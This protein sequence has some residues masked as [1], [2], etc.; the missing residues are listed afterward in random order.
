MFHRNHILVLLLVIPSISLAQVAFFEDFEEGFLD[1]L[2]WR[3][4]GTP[5]PVV[6]ASEGR[7]GS[8]ALDCN[9]DNQYC[10]AVC[11]QWDY[12]LSYLP[13]YSFYARGYQS[14]Y[15]WQ[16][17]E[18]GFSRMAHESFSGGSWNQ[19]DYLLGIALEPKISAS[20]IFYFL[21][22]DTLFHDWVPEVHNDVWLSFAVRIN[23]DGTASF[24]M[25]D[26]LVF[27]TTQQLDL[28][29]WGEQ[30]FALKGQSFGHI[31]VLDDV[32][33][34]PASLREHWESGLNPTFWKLWGSPQP[35]IVPGGGCYG[36]AALNVNGEGTWYSGASSYQVFDI[37][38][39]PCLDF[40][41]RTDGSTS[42]DL[43]EVGWSSATA[44]SY[45]GN[46]EQPELIASISVEPSVD[47]A[48][49]KV[50]DETLSIPWNRNGVYTACTIRI[51]QNGSVSFFTADTLRWTSSSQLALPVY[52]AQSIAVQGTAAESA[53]TV[54]EILV[55][56][57]F[58][59]PG[60]FVLPLNA[61]FF[62]NEQLGW[63][64]GDNGA[65]VHTSDGGASWEE[66][67]TGLPNNMNDIHFETESR[68]WIC[69]DSGVVLSTFDGTNWIPSE[70]GFSDDLNGISLASTS[71]G[72]T[73]GNGSLI[74]KTG[75]G[76]FNWVQQTCPFTGTVTGVDAITPQ[77]AFATG[78]SGEIIRTLDGDNW[79]S[80]PTGVTVDMN[81]VSFV[82]ESTGWAVGN[83]G[84]ILKTVNGGDSWIEQESGVTG[85]L[86]GVSFFDETH[87]WIVGEEGIVLYSEDSGESWILQP[88]G[89]N[90]V[91][92]LSDVHACTLDGA[93]GVSG[94]GLHGF[95]AGLTGMPGGHA[96][97]QGLV[98]LVDR[99]PCCRNGSIP[100]TLLVPG[101][102]AVELSLFDLSGR[103]VHSEELCGQHC[104]A[105][106]HALDLPPG[107]ATGVYF[108]VLRHGDEM[109]SRPVI[110]LD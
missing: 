56:P 55:Y 3:E 80:T 85:D 84:T 108:C 39:L 12:D 69:C 63:A 19:P 67:S 59:L 64:V 107:T 45:S 53:Q 17:M 37:A 24:F 2:C 8:W 16:V 75:N 92:D 42:G 93:W 28:E 15:Q 7:E 96:A 95:M 66:Q 54:D 90:D 44:L 102:G 91:P 78:T 46:E 109:A 106:D 1:S 68:G 23:P 9:G 57:S 83:H 47:Q 13:R 27:A 31:Q 105:V 98:L 25:N 61:I 40:R 71:H 104:G 18:T 110:L 5:C 60:G 20:R 62:L 103:V 52:G 77:I 50:L 35:E 11:L 33:V 58:Y 32:T 22:E 99:N 76:G 94:F 86:L 30:A 41:I 70:T 49:F 6:L 29:L 100:L 97:P 73:V 14:K 79:A 87:G 36:S 88:G 74:L 81:G 101:T 34:S 43:I 89:R 38:M 65:I 4:L 26:T 10:S 51:N 72:W 82:S 48:T 21:E